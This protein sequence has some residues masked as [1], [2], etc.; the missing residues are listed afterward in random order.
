MAT[1]ALFSGGLAREREGWC[2]GSGIF[3]PKGTTLRVVVLLLLLLCNE[4]KSADKSE[5]DGGV[6]AEAE[7]RL[8]PFSWLRNFL[9]RF[10]VGV[11]LLREQAGM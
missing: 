9:D 1:F 11:V 3:V 5:R 2:G 6:G 8:L 7:A 10:V 4:G